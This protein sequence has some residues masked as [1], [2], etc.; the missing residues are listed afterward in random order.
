MS[1][2]LHSSPA[3]QPAA[4]E[5]GGG[6]LGSPRGSD[7]G[8]FFGAA[9]GGAAAATS[10]RTSLVGVSPKVFIPHARTVGSPVPPRKVAIERKRREIAA[11]VAGAGSGE[12][13]L[14]AEGL[15]DA[16]RAAGIDFSA[17]PGGMAAPDVGSGSSSAA[18]VASLPLPLFEDADL[19]SR[20]GAEWIRIGAKALA[21]DFAGDGR[22]LWRAAQPLTYS[23]S[24]ETFSLAWTA[25]RAPL[26]ALG[27]PGEEAK[28]EAKLE[29][30]GGEVPGEDGTYGTAT[31]PRLFLCFAS[32]HPADVVRRLS[33]AFAARAAAANTLRYILTLDCMPRE[34]GEGLVKEQVAR[35]Q[36]M[37][38]AARSLQRAGE[39]AA[40]LAASAQALLQDV[41][42]DWARAMNRV[43]FDAAIKGRGSSPGGGVDALGVTSGGLPMD[44]GVLADIAP[45]PSPPAA[46][47]H[48]LRWCP[49]PPLVAPR[50]PMG[51]A[52]GA[53]RGMPFCSTPSSPWGM[54]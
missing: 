34:E 13:G 9:S 50:H 52:S 47:L 12:E 6:S 30:G 46:P 22:A 1:K 33:S 38:F 17:V 44:V 4:A 3:K 45:P 20:T 51:R 8:G 23:A 25:P 24:S 27:S 49:S 48:P 5:A 53:L 10:P 7:G 35:L 15:E 43:F 19:D 26:P 2:L 37:A 32:E 36:A 18:S 11:A 14:S 21:L 40:P 31:L 29:A 16:L 54:P 42:R 41:G 28:E 39:G